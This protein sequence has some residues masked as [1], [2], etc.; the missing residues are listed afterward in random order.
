[1]VFVNPYG[2]VII[3]NDKPIWH[4]GYFEIIKIL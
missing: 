3:L 4:K 2:D 1:M